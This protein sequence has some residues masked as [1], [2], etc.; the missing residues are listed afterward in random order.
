MEHPRITFLRS[1]YLGK[2]TALQE[3]HPLSQSNPDWIFET[4]ITID[5]TPAKKYLGRLLQ[6]AVDAHFTPETL[7]QFASNLQE[8]ESSKKTLP[9]EFRDINRFKSPQELSGA[10]DATVHVVRD[11]IIRR[12]ETD[13]YTHR[14]MWERRLIVNP[15]TELIDIRSSA[16]KIHEEMI[17]RDPRHGHS[18]P[19]IMRWLEN[20][21]DRLLPEDLPRAYSYL[22]T[23]YAN[24][25]RIVPASARPLSAHPTLRSLMAVTGKFRDDDF[26]IRDI[27]YIENG[28]IARGGATILGQ[29]ETWLLLRV[30]DKDAAIAL[31]QGTEWCTSWKDGREN[32]FEEYKRNLCYLSDKENGDRIQIHLGY[33]MIKDED[34][35][36]IYGNFFSTIKFLFDKYPGLAGAMMPIAEEEFS[37][38]WESIIAST[39]E[40]EDVDAN[41]A[42]YEIRK[43][44]EYYPGYLGIT[45]IMEINLKSEAL[46]DPILSRFSTAVDCKEAIIKGESWTTNLPAGAVLTLLDACKMRL[47]DQSDHTLFS[48]DDLN[49]NN[50]WRS[51]RDLI[52]RATE[53]G[54]TIHECGMEIIDTILS[55]AHYWKFLKDRS[56]LESDV[57]SDLDIPGI[58]VWCASIKPDSIDRLGQNLLR[59]SEE[60]IYLIRMQK[61]TESKEFLGI[62]R[63]WIVDYCQRNG[64]VSFDLNIW[65]DLVSDC[66]DQDFIFDV[67]EKIKHKLE[68]TLVI[69]DAQKQRMI[70]SI[71]FD[72]WSNLDSRKRTKVYAI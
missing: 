47:R 20:K 34:D 10:L 69:D 58:I 71:D 39:L 72:L 45:R 1:T 23:Y 17:N 25:Q 4:C 55:G 27:E 3:D 60:L 54:G 13:I 63:G 35:Y 41:D 50:Y 70:R 61:G 2:L 11:D 14:S 28:E 65:R 68:T 24:R 18:I 64:E 37:E 51:L 22:E 26:D 6:W 8:Y 48:S 33:A 16:R 53:L 46:S 67:A 56:H 43:L 9:G 57:G 59:Y 38:H 40:D 52:T 15:E 29:G 21:K 31:G 12:L 44:Q 30:N 32:M 49:D 66:N 36:D 42:L 62:L 19:H 7:P 5:P